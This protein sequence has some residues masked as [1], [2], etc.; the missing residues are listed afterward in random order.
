MKTHT[1][2][3]SVSYINIALMWW[4]ALKV[5]TVFLDSSCRYVGIVEQ[6]GKAREMERITH[7]CQ[8]PTKNK[9]RVVIEA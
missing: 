9:V 5:W 4:V 6:I 7:H 3:Y 1:F 8:Y 2:K